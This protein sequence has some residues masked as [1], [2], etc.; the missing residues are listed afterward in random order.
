MTT[1]IHHVVSQLRRAG[2]RPSDR[3]W[4]IVKEAGA[5]AVPALLDLALD[6]SALAGPEP[7]A[8]GPVHALRLL[9]DLPAPDP[10]SIERLL[11]A[12]ALPPLEPGAQPPYLWYQDLPQMVGRWGRA[13]FAA[14]RRVMLD[15]GAEGEQRAIA[16]EAI[17]NAVAIDGDL[18]EEAISV[19]LERLDSES[20]PYV[21]G[22][23]VETLAH[24]HAF[25]A[26]NRVLAAYKRGGVD[27]T[28]I[29]A[30]EA[31]RLLLTTGPSPRF[32]CVHHPLAERYDKHGPFTE[33][34]RQAMAPRYQGLGV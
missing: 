26:Y 23:V 13:G 32:A 9:G 5:L 11:R 18:R 21:V 33:E 7:A 24:L 19:L 17:G 30:A 34:Q 4:E 16:A 1:D 28:V 29:A 15:E 6:V 25:S 3:Q 27:K 14:A 12:P 10:P 22:H 20:D 2:L 8:Y 31:R